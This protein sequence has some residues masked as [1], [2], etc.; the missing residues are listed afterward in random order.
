MRESGTAR[1]REAGTVELRKHGWTGLLVTVAG[2]G[3]VGV[4]LHLAAEQAVSPAPP[5][6][7]ASLLKPAPATPAAPRDEHFVIKR[8]LPI[9]GPIRYGAWHWDETGVADG[10]LVITVDL[11]ARVLSVFRGGYEIAATAVLL[12]TSEKPTPTGIFPITEKNA[13]HKS[14]IYDG[15]PMPYMMRLTNDGISIHGTTVENGYA[16]HGCV[17]VPTPFAKKLFE[18]AGRGTPVYITRGKKIGIGDSLVS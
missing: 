4:S 13:D 17:G 12:G 9:D 18:I 16:S 2:L 10:P 11:D 5:T 1:E 14:N 7:S 3:L 8:I 15:A 6:A